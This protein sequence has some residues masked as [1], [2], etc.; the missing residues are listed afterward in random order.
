M[1]SV[2]AVVM[3]N[4]SGENQAE[5]TLKAGQKIMIAPREIQQMNRLLSTN[6]LLATPDGKNVGLVP[7]NYIRRMDVN[8]VPL[9]ET[10]DVTMDPVIIKNDPPFIISNDQPTIVNDLPATVN[11]EPPKAALEDVPTAFKLN[12]NDFPPLPIKEESPVMIKEDLTA[13][14]KD[15]SQC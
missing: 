9:G 14:V 5:L 12:V 13:T 7:V 6:W 1:N 11:I 8:Q 3:Y 2:E 4:F 15:E 10:A